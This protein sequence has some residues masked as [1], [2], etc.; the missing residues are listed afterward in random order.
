VPILGRPEA[1]KPTLPQRIWERID[2]R[3][4][5]EKLRVATYGQVRAPIHVPDFRGR[6]LLGVRNRIYHSKN[7]KYFTDF[8]FEYGLMRFGKP[9]LNEQNATPSAEQHRF[10]IGGRWG[11][12][13]RSRSSTAARW[14][15]CWSS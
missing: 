4:R 2:E 5:Q 8:L 3:T 7:W 13:T 10:F 1:P 15:F 12:L 9:W 11:S 14:N 6:R